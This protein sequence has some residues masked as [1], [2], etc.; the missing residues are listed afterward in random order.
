MGTW[1][2]GQR[3]ITI[4]ILAMGG[5]GG[6]VLSDWI[7]SVGEA[8]GYTA[9]S[10]S[11]AGVAQRTGATIYYVELFP[12]A[13]ETAGARS[14]PVLSL[15]PAPGE[16]DV[17]IASE[18]MEAGRAI[19][20][21]FSTPDRTTLIAST[22]RVYSIT[23][24][25][26]LGDGRA[27]THELLEAA[28]A[29]SKRFVGADFMELAGKAGSVI[30]ASLFGALA[31]SGALPFAREGF[32]DA[33]R[34][35]G[36]AVD[37]SLAAFALGYEAAQQPAP[38]PAPSPAPPAGPGPVPVTI[39]RRPPRDPAE[40]AAAAEEAR[41]QELAATDPGSL[42]GPALQDHA[43]KVSGFPAP[44]RSMLVHGIVRTAVHQNTAYT[45]RYL[46]RLSRI[47][48]LDGEGT[49][50]LTT[51]AARHV[52]L[53]MC[54]Q[55]TIHV[56]LQKI[57]RRRMAGIREEARAKPGQLM[58]VREYLHPQIDEITD[59]LPT[60]L[61]RR[62]AACKSFGRVV[63]K[64]TRD[65]MVVNTTAAFGFSALW[66]M[67]HMRP[68]RPRSL[69]FGREQQAIETWLDLVVATAP[70]DYELACEIVECQGVLKGYGQT[71]AHGGESFALLMNAA[72]HL[73]G[74]ADA[75]SRLAHLRK[76]A[77][78]DEDGT[79]LRNALTGVPG[80]DDAPASP[81]T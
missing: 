63:E 39:G 5:E 55:D 67:A 8:D 21:G 11:V 12:S 76:A 42:M 16:V 2:S 47:A 24:R 52:A 61:G 6:G 77:L 4:A 31:G 58:Q 51:E 3:P 14:E 80:Q 25:I 72:R 15:F 30:S 71:Y 33:V 78:A 65:G 68:L 9:Q 49:A 74:H 28:H 45:D 60:G 59:T 13:D 48:E 53:W 56:A 1:Q 34:G 18:L 75:A 43:A 35:S 81:S 69:R 64:A 54:Y 36:K 70:D 23:E 57:R 79:A 32:E 62:L 29:A 40:E 26:G 44:A 27:D 19:Q 20:R 46:E 7:V 50:R 38:I 17:V 10:T 37:T 22:N 73:T 66:V 41:H